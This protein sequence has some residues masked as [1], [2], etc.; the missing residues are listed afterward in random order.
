[1]PI[2]KGFQAC[3][4]CCKAIHYL[5][6]D[7]Y[8]D[9]RSFITVSMSPLSFVIWSNFVKRDKVKGKILANH[10]FKVWYTKVC[11]V[12]DNDDEYLYATHN[13]MLFFWGEIR[14]AC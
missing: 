8:L 13:V 9:I 5:K 1:M 11:S 10:E 4:F 2:R 12:V 6:V 3:L 7:T 14:F